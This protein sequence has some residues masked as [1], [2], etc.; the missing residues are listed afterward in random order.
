M[1]SESEAHHSQAERCS[2]ATGPPGDRIAAFPAPPFVTHRDPAASAASRDPGRLLALGSAVVGLL[3]MAWPI[4]PGPHRYALGHPSGE[5]PSHLWGLVTTTRGLWQ[6]GPFLRVSDQ[7]DVPEGVRLDLVDPLHVLLTWPLEPLLGLAGATLAWNLWHMGSLA[8]LAWGAWRLSRGLGATTSGAAVAV[9]GSMGVPYL[10]TGLPISRTELLGCLLAPLLLSLLV[11]VAQGRPR[12]VP[13]AAA[14]LSAM[15]LSGWQVLMLSFLGLAPAGLLLVSRAPERGRALL[16]LL[17]V[18]GLAALPALPMLWAHLSLDPWW[19]ER[20]EQS[21]DLGRKGAWVELPSVLRLMHWRPLFDT[22]ADA[23]PGLVLLGLGLWGLARPRSRPW[24][25]LA[26]LLFLVGLGPRLAV[27]SAADP[28]PFVAWPLASWVPAYGGL[29]DWVRLSL[30][31][32]PLLA[33]AAGLRLE[34]ARPAVLALVCGLL[35]ADGLSYRVRGAGA[36]DTRPPDDVAMAMA[37][38]PEG[39]VLELPGI[40]PDQKDDLWGHDYSMLWS[41]THGHGTSAV[42]SPGASAVLALGILPNAHRQAQGRRDP[43]C[44]AS[45]GARFHALGFRGVVLHRTRL[46]ADQLDRLEGVLDRSLGPAAGS[47]ATVAWWVLK[48]GDLGPERCNRPM[49]EEGPGAGALP[50]EE[51]APRST[52]RGRRRRG[53]RDRG[54]EPPP[55]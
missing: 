31:S 32:G 44:E 43:S 48:S 23:Y 21:V 42:P 12:R 55:G 34:R 13:A 19:T 52:E 41:L 47:T 28:V 1:D 4:L 15:A 25:L 7:V 45:E 18:A 37:A 33:V 11:E 49:A 54:A 3:A 24:S 27:T 50:A 36:F 38:L 20:L 40:A 16:R 6:H 51:G 39:P 35:L 9:A 8:A 10:W 46:S 29:S 53:P 14:V 2:P 17:A 22:R 30:I 5:G 26:L